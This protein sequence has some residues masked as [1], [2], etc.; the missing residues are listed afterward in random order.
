MTA[1]YKS[2]KTVYHIVRT[3][4]ELEQSFSLVYQEYIRRRY[5]PKHYKSK[6]R[7]SLYNA[8]PS[9]TTFVVKQANKVVA[10]VTIIP[11]SPL[12]LPMDKIYKKELDGL[13][14]KGQRVSEV[15]QLSIDNS[16]YPK[17][18][19]SMFNFN[20]LIFIFRLFKLIFDYA[21]HVANLDELCIAI[22]PKQQPLYKFLF[23]EKMGG[24]KYYGSV[25]KAPAVA[26]HLNMGPELKKKS[27]RRI[28]V[29]KI[30]Y[31]GKTNPEVF[32]N[33]YVFK[34]ADLEYFFL[35]KSDIFGKATK[36][37]LACIK[38][39][40]PKGEFNKILEKI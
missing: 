26:F 25:N 36:K 32:K 16:L 5:I 24:L 3:R 7:L 4:K 30:F 19:F 18:W 40:Y 6:L 15:S 8:V 34:A 31:G 27:K 38:G 10:T 29:C 17:G 21:R 2:K 37:Q 1:Q 23:F 11:D 13:R 22:N 39:C 33:K 14:K 12:G 20:K 28:G 35:K 9:T